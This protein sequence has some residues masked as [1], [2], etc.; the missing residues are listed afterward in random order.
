MPKD[1]CDTVYATDGYSESVGNL[2][3]LS[4]ESDN[5]FSDG[6]EQQ[7]ATMTG[8][9]EKGYTATLTVPV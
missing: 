2:S 3:Q 4:L 7:L 5:I 1:V 9:V 6:Y 8:S